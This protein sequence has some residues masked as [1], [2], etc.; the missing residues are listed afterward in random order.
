MSSCAQPC[1]ASG[2]KDN[3][4]VSNNSYKR[5][6]QT[7]KEQTSKKR[8]EATGN[9]SKQGN[10]GCAEIGNGKQWVSNHLGN[11]ESAER[12]NEKVW[13]S[14]GVH[15]EAG[16]SATLKALREATGNNVKHG[17]QQCR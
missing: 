6:H 4:N 11:F 2:R 17:K 8:W 12:G 7:R 3:T 14:N 1:P 16:V 15:R 9:N 13:G 5:R 10:F